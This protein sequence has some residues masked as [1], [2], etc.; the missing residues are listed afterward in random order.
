MNKSFFKSFLKENTKKDNNIRLKF[1][2]KINENIQIFFDK[3]KETSVEE[4]LKEYSPLCDE[5]IIK[6]LE[7]NPG[8]EFIAGRFSINLNENEK[9]VDL[10]VK[11]Y[12]QD[13]TKKW[14][15]KENSNQMSINKFNDQNKKLI[16]EKKILEFEINEP[17]ILKK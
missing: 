11:F 13:N 17:E 5:T 16:L 1:F 9:S 8:W 14:I 7:E 10:E 15:Q 6:T 2:D 4:V 12:F 3:I